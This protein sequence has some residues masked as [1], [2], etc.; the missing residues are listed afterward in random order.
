MGPEGL[1][2]RQ[3]VPPPLTAVWWYRREK[4]A[5]FLCLCHLQPVKELVHSLTSCSSGKQALNPNLGITAELTL[6]TG[7]LV[8]Q[9]QDYE[10]GRSCPA[11]S[12]A[13]W[14]H[15]KGRQTQSC[16][17]PP[18]TVGRAGPEIMREG[19][20]S[21]LLSV[22]ALRRVAPE[23]HLGNT[24]ELALLVQVWESQSRSLERKSTGPASC[25]LLQGVNQ[26]G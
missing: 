8:N 6:L 20:L 5:R 1:R 13:I 15:W 16:P 17:Q 9:S 18:V 19:E 4:D 25:W 22:E 14:W 11:P 10:F 3:L 2:L 24:V 26:P 12:S 23:P 7:V 21:L